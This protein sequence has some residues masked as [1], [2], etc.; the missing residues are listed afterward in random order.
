MSV[1]CDDT[2]MTDADRVTFDV[3]MAVGVLLALIGVIAYVATEF[4]SATA[5]IPSIFGI[6]IVAL[7]SIG[8]H[9]DRQRLA[10]YGLGLF[11]VLGIAGSLRAVP[12]ILA[13]A[14]GGTVDSPIAAG[15][16]AAMIAL[17]LVVLVLVGRS[18]LEQQ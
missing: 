16:Q 10:I 9:T 18:V 11:A 12:D 5:L 1:P 6:A 3:S 8:R 7:A 4:A 13:L 17:C 14:T 15:S 2:A